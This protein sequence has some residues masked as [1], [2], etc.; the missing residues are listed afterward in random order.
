MNHTP[1]LKG[2]R[3]E[4]NEM[5][6]ILLIANNAGSAEFVE[7]LLDESGLD[8]YA[9]DHVEGVSHALTPLK[10]ER[11]DIVLLDLPRPA[12]RGLDCITQ[13]QTTA[14]SVPLLALSDLDDERLAIQAVRRGAQDFLAKESLKGQAL[15]RALR[16][17]VERKR[18]EERLS[19]LAQFDPLTGLVN[20]TCFRDRLNRAILRANRNDQTV[21]VFFLDLDHFKAIND[22][23][24]RDRGDALLKSVANRLQSCLR[25]SD[26]IAR[27]GGDEFTILL[28][29]LKAVEDTAIVGSKVIDAMAPAFT[30]GDRE[31]FLSASIG[32]VVYPQCGETAEALMKHAEVAMYRA[33]EKGRNTYQYYAREM[34]SEAD[35]RLTMRSHLHRAL[36]RRDFEIYYQPQLDLFTN[37]IVG[38]E[39]L[40][41]WQHPELGLISPAQFIPMA[42]E[43]GLIV[44][45]GA[46]VLEE[47]CKQ[48][49]AWQ[50]DGLSYVRMAV[51][52][53]ARQFRPEL[54]RT[55]AEALRRSGLEP[56]YLEVE[57]TE[58]ALIDSFSSSMI[59]CD[60]KNMGVQ[61]AVDD[62]GTGYSSL[63]YLKRFPLDTLKIDRSFVQNLPHDE[64]E[65]SITSAIITLA[66]SLR[67]TVIAEGVETEEQMEF[68][69][70]QGCDEL[71]GY[72]HCRPLPADAVW[73]WMQENA[74]MSATFRRQP[75]PLAT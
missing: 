53:S 33:K 72:Y 59:L 27:L 64:D 62:F 42:E 50:D 15:V 48:M 60:L 47:A 29:G 39:A 41:R 23:L 43:T 2:L 66:H 75:H 12:E 65:A 46:W 25:R 35:A 68:L 61:I 4:D 19:Y 28:E 54:P 9:F 11:V 34:N 74:R 30:I 17:A 51:N 37:Q 10:D 67:L 40:L 32:I 49:R 57:L 18:S 73:E 36:E 7:R 21:A 52:F 56:K 44:P 71:Q 3:C 22:T 6:R 5:L 45:V 31:I 69:R 55:V 70:D 26:T 8:H 16:L 1:A 14:P 13:I 38:V 63:S 58:S 20:R 24:G